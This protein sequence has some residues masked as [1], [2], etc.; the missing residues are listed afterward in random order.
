MS[1]PGGEYTVFHRGSATGLGTTMEQGAEQAPEIM[2]KRFLHALRFALLLAIAFTIGWTPTHKGH[3]DEDADAVTEALGTS[4]TAANETHPTA[5]LSPR[6]D[7]RPGGGW[8]ND[9]RIELL[10]MAKEDQQARTAMSQEWEES[11]QADSEPLDRL[12]EIDARN[13]KRMRE[14]VAEY[15]WPGKSLVAVDG[16]HAAW[17]VVQHAD[18]DLAFQTQCL[19][20]MTQAAEEGDASW[21]HVAYLTD[22]VLV[23]EGKEQLYGTQIRMVG[24]EPVPLPIEDKAHVDERRERVGLGPLEDY[25]ELFRE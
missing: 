9:L 12:A 17:L 20:L 14:I 7:S 1:R 23:A 10:R 25:L 8:N 5:T 11:G 18:A 22:R 21:G 16:A 3:R 15:G 4:A 19:E 24:G 2:T 6:D 13:T